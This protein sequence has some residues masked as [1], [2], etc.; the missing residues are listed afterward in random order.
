MN[1]RT[2]DGKPRTERATLDEAGF[3]KKNRNHA[4]H[5]DLGG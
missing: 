1:M 2:E 4:V 5:L 3:S